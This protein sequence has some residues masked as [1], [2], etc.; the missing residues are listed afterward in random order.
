MDL[1]KLRTLIQEEAAKIAQPIDQRVQNQHELLAARLVE[2]AAGRVPAAL[3]EYVPELAHVVNHPQF[4]GL[5]RQQLAQM[6]PRFLSDAQALASLASGLVALMDKKNMPAAPDLAAAAR[7]AV[8]RRGLA[9][10]DV[11]AGAPGGAS[12]AEIARRAASDIEAEAVRF[13]RYYV[14]RETDLAEAQA[15]DATDEHGRHTIDAYKAALARARR[16]SR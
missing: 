15:L 5:I 6:D 14:D 2:E 3:A 12:A 8:S 13:L 16:A 11:G 1:E 9:G 7:G 10:A 4:D